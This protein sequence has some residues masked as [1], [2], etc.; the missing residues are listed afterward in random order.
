[1]VR[2]ICTD[3]AFL[4]QKAEPATPEDLRA[5]G[6]DLLDTLAHHKD[7]LCGHGGQYDRGEQADHRL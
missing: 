1:M 2:E 3:Q 6:P 4:A 7:G 5:G